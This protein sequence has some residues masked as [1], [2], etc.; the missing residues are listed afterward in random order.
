MAE[1]LGV[2]PELG[3]HVKGLE[4]P[5]H[6][7]RAYAGQALS[8]MT[9][10]C[11]A[12]HQKCDWFQVE[13]QSI[14]FPEYKINPGDRFDITGREAG[15]IAFQDIRAIDDSAVSCDFETPPKFSDIAKYISYATDFK[16]TPKM[17]LQVG[18]RM[19]NIKRL[20]SCNLG[21]TREDDRLPKIA[22]QTLKSG[23]TEG[24]VLDLE[25]NLKTYYK[26]RGWD[27][28][29]GRPTK[30]KLEE[31][32]IIGDDSD[33][34]IEAKEHKIS[35]EI[36]EEMERRKKKYIP[37]LTAK[38]IPTED[39][40]EY[41]G[42]ITLFAQ[43]EEDFHDEFGDL[44]DGIQLAIKALPPEQWYWINLDKGNFSSGR[45]KM[46][47]PTLTLTF[48]DQR[49]YDNIM[50]MKLNPVTAVLSNRLKVKPMGKVKIFQNFIGLYL[51]KFNLKF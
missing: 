50:N 48:R 36:F 14:S 44:Q 31:L 17:L 40:E 20:I 43:C 5:M 34:I 47:A 12:N 13:T 25:K 21:I 1:K 16:Y 35:S 23:P 24:V 9:A 42:F 32:R 4:I 30:A 2:D 33:V 46:D 6:D 41:L 19:T 11:G 15:V 28:K 45:G 10:C 49:V 38:I 7:A 27:W 8:Y 3:A 26:I 37:L 51:N 22:S 29:T 39:M 18:E